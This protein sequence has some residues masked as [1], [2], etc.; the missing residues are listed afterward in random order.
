[1]DMELVN[2]KVCG[3]QL[4]RY[5]L[6]LTLKG[7]TGPSYVSRQCELKKNM[8]PVKKDVLCSMVH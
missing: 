3:Q 2:G 4:S 6:L 1:M 5:D 8:F 7:Y